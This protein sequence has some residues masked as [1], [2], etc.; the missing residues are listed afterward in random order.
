MLVRVPVTSI[1]LRAHGEV[2]ELLL[3]LNLPKGKSEWGIRYE[4]LR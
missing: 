3:K 2:R 1:L 4:L